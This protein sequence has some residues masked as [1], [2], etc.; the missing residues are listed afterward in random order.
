[1]L[2][3]ATS[4]HAFSVMGVMFCGSSSLI[5]IVGVVGVALSESF[6]FVVSVRVLVASRLFYFD[7]LDLCQP[8]SICISQALIQRSEA[9][10]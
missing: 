9:H 6:S 3:P 7:C 2:I 8:Q 5:L 4:S 10:C 1:M